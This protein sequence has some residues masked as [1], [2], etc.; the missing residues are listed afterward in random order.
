MKNGVV[1]FFN[2]SKG[3]GFIGRE[4]G[5][6]DVFVHISSLERSGLKSLSEG[7]KVSFE[8]AENKGKMSA[9]NI[10]VEE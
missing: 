10:K 3:Y 6:S 5:E 1:K 9:A 8:I 4:D 7:Q 2:G